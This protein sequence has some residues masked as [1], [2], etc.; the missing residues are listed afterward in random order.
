[1]VE[2]KNAQWYTLPMLCTA[3]PFT[4]LAV[5]QAF[6]LAYDPTQVMKLAIQ[7]H[8]VIGHDN[9]VPPDDPNYIDYSVTPDPD[10][11]K[12]M[13]KK[14]GHAGLKLDLYSSDYDSV[15]TPLALAMKDSMANAGI[16]LN[17][18][19]SP[20]DSYYTKIWMQKPFMTSY[21]YTGRPID[22]LLSEI[23]QTGSSYNES[24]LSNPTLDGLIASARKETDDAKRKSL[25]QEAQKLL[26]DKSGTIMPFFASRMTGISKK[27]VN[28]HESGFEFDYV[29]IGLSA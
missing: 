5:R 7:N 26:V 28:Y 2:V 4:S 19:N 25:Y 29:N 21:W 11:A 8:G 16:T 3:A 12:S 23:F 22:Q 24:K 20:S 18:Q 10:K 17:I 15:L 9:P 27:V 1:V 6:K 13:L 14:A